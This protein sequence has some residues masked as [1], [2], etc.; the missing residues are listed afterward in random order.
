[1]SILHDEAQ[2]AI[3][4]AARR[5]LAPRDDK[6]RL[7]ALLEVT[8]QWDL[9]FWAT[10][11]EQGWCG[12]GIPEEFDGIGLGLIELGL[13]A[14]AMGAATAGA[15]FLDSSF[16]AARL[17]LASND[18]ALQELWLP[19][20]ASG[21]A[22]GAIAFA[23][24]AE[25]L[26]HTPAMRL[27]EGRL[28]GAKPA[29]TAALAADFAIVWCSA[30]EQPALVF[31]DL[32]NV[33]RTAVASFD[34][35][36]LYAD[37]R[38]DGAPAELL[39]V[40]ERARAAA[41]DALGAAAVLAAHEQVG[42]AEA[43]MLIARDYANTRRAFGQPIGAFQSIKHRIAEL[44]GLIEIARANAIHA[45]ARDGEP[46]FLAAAAAARLSATEAYDAAA[47]DCVQIHGAIGVTWD[48]GLHL[49]T[50]RARSLAVELGNTLFWEDVLVDQLVL[51]T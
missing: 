32:T 1:M 46:E 25:P 16:A 31:A 45:A 19:R 2:E 39:M 35:G 15:P 29:V 36:R 9:A 22:V 48:A 28:T 14:Q 17:L 26:P 27:V 24:G 41:L 18:R 38:F 37:L 4:E 34:N 40:G 6:A 8:G 21:D 10:A 42:G 13:V 50:R 12:V 47:R 7:L 51:A 33:S 49:H 20:L 30:G 5:A 43:L 44:Y 3:G 11:R 23:D